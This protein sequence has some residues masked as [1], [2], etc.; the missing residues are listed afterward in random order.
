MD[1]G[2]RIVLLPTVY[3]SLPFLFSFFFSLLVVLAFDT[4][5]VRVF[6]DPPNE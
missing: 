1:A 2:R 5:L 3:A 6:S 4:P